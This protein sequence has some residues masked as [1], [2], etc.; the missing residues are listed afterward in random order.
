MPE[1]IIKETNYRGKVL[2]QLHD[3]RIT[4]YRK[5]RILT[6]NPE[7][8]LKAEISLPLPLLKKCLCKWRLTE[9]IL[10]MD[11]RWAYETDDENILILFE[12]SIFRINL[13]NG[14]YQKERCSFRGKPFSVCRYK[15]KL[16]FGDYGLNPD[17]LPVNIYCRDP[18]GGWKILYTFNAGEVRHIHNIIAS[19]NRIYVLTG[20]EDAESGIWYTDDEFVTVNPFLKGSQQYRCCQMLPTPDG[21]F[22][23]TDAPSECNWL[24]CAAGDVVKQLDEIDGTCIYGTADA[25]HLVFS[26]TVEADAHAGN[27]LEYWLTNKPGKGIKST[28][29][30]VYILQDGMLRKIA[31]FSHDRLPLRLFQYATCYFSNIMN[32]IVYFSPVSVKKKDMRI[33]ECHLT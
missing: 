12:N 27:M 23:V 20:V 22:F 3:G 19:G 30:S 24:Y 17:H 4:A 1:T 15:D 21:L 5:G 13:T 9:R 25:D 28:N 14:T 31:G 26:T 11:V 16:L 18:D 10:H 8:H 33:F 6:Y 7:D 2:L 29:C 32:D